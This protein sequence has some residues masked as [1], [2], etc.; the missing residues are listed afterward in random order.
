MIESKN[1]VPRS[2]VDLAFPLRILVGAGFATIVAL[3]IAQVFFRVALDSPLVWSE[4]LSRLLLVWVTFI[5]A[6]VI[7]WD[8]THL[9]VD[10]VFVHL[11]P[12]IRRLV[13]A[14]N[15]V[16]A[17]VFLA[18][19]AWYSIKMV[20]IEHITTLGS[21]DIPASFLRVPATI[22]GVLMIVFIVLRRFY[23][24]RREKAI[25]GDAFSDHKEP[26]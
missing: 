23:L 26:M 21:M 7:C 6:A 14:F 4:E 13:R 8:G 12:R 5:G 10:V 11:G 3:T 2:P 1:G 19:L 16:V 18:V 17:L 20:E 24:L 22:G 15:S 9:N 25:K